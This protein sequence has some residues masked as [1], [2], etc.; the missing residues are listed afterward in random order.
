MSLCCVLLSPFHS[1]HSEGPLGRNVHPS[2]EL[3]P[4]PRVSSPSHILTWP[5]PAYVYLPLNLEP[6]AW[7]ENINNL[8]QCTPLDGPAVPRG[9]GSQLLGNYKLSLQGPGA[10]GDLEAA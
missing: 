3:F 8:L 1:F 2:S 7:A 9:L 10:G 6:Q 5:A 4:Q